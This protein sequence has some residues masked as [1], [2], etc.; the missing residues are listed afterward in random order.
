MKWWTTFP[1]L[2][3]L[4]FAI[5]FVTAFADPTS[6]PATMKSSTQPTSG[7][8]TVMLDKLVDLYQPVPFD[9]R[10]HAEMAEMWDGCVTCHHRPPGPT[11]REA[12]PG[13]QTQQ[14]DSAE[15]PACKSCHPVQSD[16]E[17]LRIPTLKGAYH[18]QCLNCHREWTHENACVMCHAARDGDASP[19]KVT[20]D[21]IVGR[22]HPPVK[23]PKEKLYRARFTPVAGPNVMFRH[24]EHVER[25]GIKCVNCHRRDSCADCHDKP[26][27]SSTQSVH[28]L[29]SSR[30]W[31]ETH[32]PCASCHQNDTC[33]H[34]HFTDDGFAPERFTH[35]ATKQLLDKDHDTLACG[36]C[37][38]RAKFKEFLSCG[39]ASCHQKR[40]V[41]F[42]T[43][44]PGER[45]REIAPATLPATQPATAPS[46]RPTIIRIRRG[47]S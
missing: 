25:F 35:S 34:C 39:D 16:T 23:A 47:G 12:E 7:P 28:V 33:N 1:V 41:S 44:L 42:P 18:R 40:A 24:D 27:S 4:A 9:H 8:A 21:D 38:K 37:H 19:V 14:A 30:T 31:K 15:I 46:T 29:Q 10:T 36:D 6:L 2:V 43:D 32:G 11:T 26:K 20:P 13:A 45:V 17:N 22:M 5:F 3:F